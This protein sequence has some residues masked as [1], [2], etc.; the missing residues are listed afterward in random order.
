MDYRLFNVQQKPD[1]YISTYEGVQAGSAHL[2]G[3]FC[4]HQMIVEDK[5][6]TS[7]QSSGCMT[8]PVGNGS[9]TPMNISFFDLNFSP[10][11]SRRL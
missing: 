6:E 8:T 7:V 11:I 5:D 10:Q 1:C 9:R 2:L 3:T 4:G